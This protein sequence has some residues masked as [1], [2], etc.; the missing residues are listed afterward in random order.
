MVAYY[1]LSELGYRLPAGA[2]V[3]APE[4]L[5]PLDEATR[6]LADAEAKAAAIVADAEAAH[7]RE[8]ARG[9]EE[10]LARARLEALE[11]L[12]QETDLLD[13]KLRAAERDLADLV[14]AG[15]RKLIDGFD[16]VA[17]AE[18]VVRGAL[19]QMRREKKAELRV[20]P[21][22]VLHFRAAVGDIVKEFPEIDLV[23]VVEDPA[24]AP[25]QVVVETS[26]GRVEGDFGRR[27]DELIDLIRL[28]AGR[29]A[30]DEPPE[31]SHKPPEAS[32]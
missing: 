26:I 1:R 24:L 12:L 28:S 32:P 4:A 17:R 11:R 15:V 20:S 8:C 9:Y 13:Q 21:A 31:A 25:P 7:A 2:H 16:D 10:G 3:L 19:K 6:L 30:A 5:A 22:Q 27:L 23:D 29:R 14:A 18:A